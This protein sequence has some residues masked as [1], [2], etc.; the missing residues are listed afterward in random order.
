[1]Y[2]ETVIPYYKREEGASMGRFK[3]LFTPLV[4][5]FELFEEERRNMLNRILDLMKQ[6]S[7]RGNI[8]QKI[9]DRSERNRRDIRNRYRKEL[10]DVKSREKRSLADS[11]EETE[12]I[13]KTISEEKSK[14]LRWFEGRWTSLQK[15]SFFFLSSRRVSK[16]SK[17]FQAA[18]RRARD[19]FKKK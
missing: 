18:H 10:E 5:K 3:D 6:L 19:K 1:M 7:L 8:A 4:K 16:P 2:I 15:V 17:K 11:R 12:R 13:K 9:K 14:Y